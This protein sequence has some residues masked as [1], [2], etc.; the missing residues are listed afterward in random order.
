MGISIKNIPSHYNNLSQKLYNF[1][2][3]TN[4]II[5]TIASKKPEKKQEGKI[6]HTISSS[7]IHKKNNI[8]L[9]KILKNLRKDQPQCS[10][11]SYKIPS[12]LSSTSLEK[13][14]EGVSNSM[15]I[16]NQIFND[17]IECFNV[18]QKM[19]NETISVAITTVNFINLKSEINRIIADEFRFDLNSSRSL[20]FTGYSQSPSLNHYGRPHAPRYHGGSLKKTK[21]RV[22]F[23]SL[24]K[25]NTKKKLK[26][27][28][29]FHK[30][31]NSS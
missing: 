11:E 22:Q 29:K 24:S 5:T 19:I 30:K 18:L 31:P 16:N 2:Q 21:K 17:I 9:L 3:K 15:F 6:T 4:S 14:F 27:H 10:I 28:S 12:F 1:I 26:M 23:K 20:T 13:S 25:S 7:T 8:F